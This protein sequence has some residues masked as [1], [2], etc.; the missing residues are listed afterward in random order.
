M[1]LIQ[2]FDKARTQSICV[3]GWFL[4]PSV[5]RVAFRARESPECRNHFIGFRIYPVSR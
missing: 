5:A 2:T 3:T 1:R 4:V